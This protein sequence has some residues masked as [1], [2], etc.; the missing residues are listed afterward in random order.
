MGRSKLLDTAYRL[1]DGFN[2]WDENQIMSC[3][4]EDCVH[5]FWPATSPDAKSNDNATAKAQFLATKDV[6]RNF[7]VQIVEEIEDPAAHRVVFFAHSTM[8]TPKGDMVLDYVLLL[9]LS[10]QNDKIKRIMQMNQ[11]KFV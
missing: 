1:I 7:H 5:E 2:A 11:F 8:D 9:D 6:F 4:T 10:E 3:R